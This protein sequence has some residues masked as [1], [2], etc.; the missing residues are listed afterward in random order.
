MDHDQSLV[1]KL[2]SGHISGHMSG[3]DGLLDKTESDH[4]AFSRS[5]FQKRK[6]SFSYSLTVHCFTKLTIELNKK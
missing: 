6:I 2:M 3:G 5:R 4:L 1:T